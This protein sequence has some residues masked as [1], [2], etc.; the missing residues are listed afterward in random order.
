MSKGPVLEIQYPPD[1]DW[2]SWIERCDKIHDYFGSD[3]NE[4]HR[5][6]GS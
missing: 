3:K 5:R 4:S 2:R 1:I 6:L